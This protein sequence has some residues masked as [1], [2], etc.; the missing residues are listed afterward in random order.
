MD[1]RDLT[2]SRTFGASRILGVV[3]SAARRRLAVLT[4]EQLAF[5]LAPILGGFVLL[6][7]LGT[8]V[9]HWYWLAALAVAGLAIAFVRIRARMLSWYRTAQLLDKRL[10]LNDS[11]STAWFVLQDRPRVEDGVALFQ[12]QQAEN[13]A[14]SIDVAH[15]FPIV[16]RRAWAITGALAAVAF[17][18]FAVRYL[19]TQS[20]SLEQAL[21]PVQITPIFERLSASLSAKN[22]LQGSDPAAGNNPDRVADPSSGQPDQKSQQPPQVQ[23]DQA[24]ESPDPNGKSASSGQLDPGKQ[25][26]PQSGEG[27]AQDGNSGSEKAATQQL[28]QTNATQPDS[29]GAALKPELGAGEQGSQGLMD[30]MRDALSSLMAK[31]QQNSAEKSPQNGHPTDENKAASQ[32]SGKAQ[33]GQQQDARDQQSSQEQSSESEAQGQASEKAQASQGRSSDSLPEKGA[34]A[35]S[36]IGRQDG[37]KALKEAEQL[38][39]MGKLAE[40]IGKRSASLTG[41]MTIETPSGKQQLKTAYSQK[42]GRHSDS[43]GEINRDEIPLEDQQYVRTYMEMVRKQAKSEK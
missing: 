20:L 16:F 11:L 35:H 7:L 5:A 4:V 33:Q 43:G 41:D 40:I 30:K 1:G 36:G 12:L 9:L 6:L 39:A 23:P 28:D 15:A 19:V 25:G 13:L 17:G 22:H 34:D 32:S 31:M 21:I 37:D 2:D 3:R 29:R 24:G 27:Q 42:L 18:L 38:Q 14:R 10:G 26:K 8:Q